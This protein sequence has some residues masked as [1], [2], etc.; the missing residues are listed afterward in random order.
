[1]G[2]G[3][4]WLGKKSYK[5]TERETLYWIKGNLA[6]YISQALKPPYTIDWIA[7]MVMRETGILITRWGSKVLVRDMHALMRGDY[8]QRPGE[9]EKS[10]HGYGYMQADIGSYPDFVKSGDWKDPSK[11]FPF[12][13]KV[14][15]EKRIYIQKNSLVTGEELEK[16][17]TEAYNA[18]QG[19]ALKDLADGHIDDTYTYNHDYVKE[20]WR[21]RSIYKTL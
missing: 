5:M 19:R 14:L 2:R 16:A 20:V 17:I 3:N 6:S 9:K 1:M 10:Y 15:E 21:F 8:S 7:A 13:I 11:V 4:N 12:A 18:G